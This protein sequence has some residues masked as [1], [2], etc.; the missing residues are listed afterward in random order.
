M[1]KL[2]RTLKRVLYPEKYPELVSQYSD[3]DFSPEVDEP[4]E[5]DWA[6]YAAITKKKRENT[7]RARAILHLR[8]YKWFSASAEPFPKEYHAMME[9][10]LRR[11]GQLDEFMA[12][13]DTYGAFAALESKVRIFAD[14]Y[15][16]EVAEMGICLAYLDCNR[17]FLTEAI[18]TDGKEER[19]IFAKEWAAAES[20]AYVHYNYT[21]IPGSEFYFKMEK[22]MFFE[23][24]LWDTITQKSADLKK[25]LR[26]LKTYVAAVY[27]V[28]DASNCWPFISYKMEGTLL[29]AICD[30][31]LKVYARE[32]YFA[33]TY[34]KVGLP[35]DRPTFEGSP[36]PDLLLDKFENPRDIAVIPDIMQTE[37]DPEALPEI[38]TG[39][40]QFLN[41]EVY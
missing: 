9:K 25:S 10:A 18:G 3:E 23:G 33:S 31:C 1:D 4:T 39:V 13:M 6:E 12:Y 30:N 26:R 36:I 41:G 37:L 19:D 17:H 5:A 22:D 34:R 7:A 8:L 29:D 20:N 27:E 2:E 40:R 21:P 15:V 38:I 16:K 11:D 14:A 24:G 28:I 32:E 35:A